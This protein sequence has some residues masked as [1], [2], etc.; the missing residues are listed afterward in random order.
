MPVEKLKN[1]FAGRV[2][3]AGLAGLAAITPLAAS[4]QDAT[5]TAMTRDQELAEFNEARFAAGAYAREN[6]AIAV[7]FHIG[8][9]IRGLENSTEAIAR[10]EAHFE[11][12]F[13]SHGIT[14]ESF[15][16]HNFGTTATG[17]T[18][19]YGDKVYGTSDGVIDLNLQEGADAIPSVVESL[20]LYLQTVQARLDSPEPA[21][22]S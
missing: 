3:G 5:P 17:L 9:D 8:D 22:G 10:V 4:A 1:N 15:H 14:A 7:L 2:L 21:S 16:S 13:A 18:Y 20:N 12:Q 19:Y 11:Q 6:N